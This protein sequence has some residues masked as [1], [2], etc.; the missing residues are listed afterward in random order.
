MASE[1]A[2]KNAQKAVDDMQGDAAR[3]AQAESAIKTMLNRVKKETGEVEKAVEDLK[4]AEAEIDKDFILKLK[5]G[6]LPKQAALIGLLLF[7]VRSIGD[8]VIS[9]TDETH[10]AAALIQGGI[11]L[12]CA[13]FLFLV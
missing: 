4:K 2:N 8:T 6:G 1:S 12:F 5:R 10:L 9:F 3:L 7:S 11:A 13:A